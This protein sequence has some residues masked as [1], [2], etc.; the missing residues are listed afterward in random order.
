VV[1][2]GSIN[3]DLVFEADRLPGP[4]ETVTGA[5]FERHGGGKGANQAV[6]A[7]RAGAN[8]RFVGAVGNDE[9]GAQALG[10]L[11]HEGVDVSAVLRLDSVSTGLAAIVVGAGGE[12]QIAVASGANAELDERHVERAL[13]SME[14]PADGVC[15]LNLEIPDAA[16]LAAAQGI[17]AAGIQTIVINPA[18][19]R[20]LQHELLE[21]R[22]LLTPNAT[23]ATALTGERSSESAARVLSAR[24]AAPAIVTLGADGAVLA[25]GETCERFAA[26]RVHAVDTTGAGDVFSGSLAAALAQGSELA[27][28]VTQAVA[29]A[30]RSVQH[31]GARGA[32]AR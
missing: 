18:P 20:D 9:L 16:L 19:A 24:T 5:R 14:L 8:V 1:I 3:I 4:G 26:P 30:A 6:A 11:E 22:P 7:A 27:D 12:N 17:S 15:L 13:E 23:E 29:A 2:V 32:P 21:L 25:A 10:E 31:P 28:A